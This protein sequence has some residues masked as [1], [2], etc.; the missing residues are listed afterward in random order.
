VARVS[1]QAQE[2]QNQLVSLNAQKAMA[3]ESYSQAQMEIN[4]L[5]AQNMALEEQLAASQVMLNALDAQ[6]AD[7]GQQVNESAQSLETSMTYAVTLEGQIATLAKERDRLMGDLQRASRT[8]AQLEDQVQ[9]LQA[10]PASKPA[11]GPPPQA[12]S[13]ARGSEVPKAA[14]AMGSFKAASRLQRPS[15]PAPLEP[16]PVEMEIFETGAVEHRT[17][18]A[19]TIG[20]KANQF[21]DVDNS[22]PAADSSLPVSASKLFSGKSVVITGRLSRLS[23]QQVEKLIVQAG[24]TVAKMP[25]SKTGYVVVGENPGSKLKKAEKY[26]IPQLN[27]AQFLAL[28]G[29]SPNS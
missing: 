2:A 11:S 22:S 16:V 9:T 29:L 20:D 5:K 14:E 18:E 7:L 21:A 17:A 3:E 4:T 12:G 10:A 6:I 26:R 28:M 23:S 27:E 15:P 1:Q 13:Q 24:G 25:N 8:V 19:E